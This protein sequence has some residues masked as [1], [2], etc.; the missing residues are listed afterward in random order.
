MARRRPILYGPNGKPVISASA[1][2][3]ASRGRRAVNWTPTSSSINQL[4]G[5]GDVDMLRNRVRD[6]LRRNPW[7]SAASDSRVANLI[8]TGI[9][10]KPNTD[11]EEL[12]LVLK[13]RWEDFVE[14]CDADG[15][16]DFYGL[17]TLVCR[18]AH[19]AGDGLLRFRP[20]RASDGLTVPLQLQ[21]L[22]P[23]MLDASKNLALTNGVI[24]AGVEF[25]AIGRRRAYWMFR[26]HPGEAIRSYTERTDSVPVPADQIV[27]VYH[28]QRAGQVR[29]VPGMAVALACLH[30]IRET[31]DAH[32]MKAKIQNLY[33]TF[34]TVPSDEEGSVFDAAGNVLDDDDDVPTVTAEA[35]S[36]VLLPPGHEVTFGSPP[37][38]GGDWY[39]SFMRM[40]LHKVAAG[41]GATYEHVTGDY[42]G[43]N[44]TSIR[45]ALIELRRRLEQIQRNM[46]IFQMCRR[47]YRRWLETAILAG[48]V[49]IPAEE[50]GNLRR[51]MRARWGPPGWEYVEPEKDIKAAVRRIRAGLSSREIEAGK[52]GVD[53]EE[54]DHQIAAENERAESLGLKFD[55]NP[56]QDKDGSATAAAVGDAGDAGEAGDAGT[57]AA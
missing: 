15:T 6:E 43:V 27:H 54:L 55:S 48:V 24:R 30:E 19:E 8:G 25:D 35:G 28:V 57:A 52:L 29:G 53:V 42:T 50:R 12:A 38:V 56:S 23:E 44:F 34:E 40:E 37:T 45:A 49:K 14:E 17:E 33:A 7:A 32:V 2:D 5:S 39:E 20:R 10:P 9:K 21:A 47:V 3:A 18:E 16:S 11:N 1:W 41:A 51:L 13:D 36:H 26:I 4:L 22:E 31:D 46:V